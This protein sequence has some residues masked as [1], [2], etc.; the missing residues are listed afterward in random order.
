MF[1]CLNSNILMLLRVLRHTSLVGIDP[2]YLGI[3]TIEDLGDL[4]KSRSLSLD[5]KDGNEDEFEADPYSINGVELPSGLEVL[6][7]V[8]VDVLVDSQ[9][10]LNEQVHDH[11]T[12]GANLEWQDLDGVSDE[13]TRPGKRVGNGEDPYHG[14]DGLSGS[15]AL[16][17]L[18]LRRADRPD[19]KGKAHRSSGGY[20]ERAATDLVGEKSAGDRD[21]ERENGKATVETELGVSISD[22]DGL[23][24]IGRVV[25]NEAVTRPL[26]EQTEGCQKHKSV[27]VAA[28][29]KKVEVR[30]SLLVQELKAESF[31]D[32]SVLKLDSRIVDISVGVVLAKDSKGF[33]ISLFRNQPTRGLG[34]EPD[35]SQ[36]ND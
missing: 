28:G 20:E 26:R 29:L 25:R 18:L 10:D 3:F 30:R 31:L 27:S 4:F 16:L 32:L 13:K 9:S 34:N 35:E 8:G 14:N 1:G 7:A 33:F 12:L 17:G 22:V 2:S 24:D 21:D 6:E 5:V 19:D 11:K 23:V 36:L 15:L